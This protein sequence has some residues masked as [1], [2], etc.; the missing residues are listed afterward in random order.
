M[1]FHKNIA[2]GC[3]HFSDFQMVHK[4][5]GR[6]TPNLDFKVTIFINV[7]YTRQSYT[8]NDTLIGSSIMIY[9]WCHFHDFQLP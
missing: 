2:Y 8:Y 9:E 7:K 4:F 3:V 5:V 6:M 1:R